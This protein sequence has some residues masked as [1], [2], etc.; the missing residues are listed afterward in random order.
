MSDNIW[1]LTFGKRIDAIIREVQEYHMQGGYGGK[2]NLPEIVKMFKSA[3][4]EIQ[5]VN[6]KLTEAENKILSLEEKIKKME[7]EKNQ[8]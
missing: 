7:T 2:M 6:N 4:T 3:T 8:A 1:L 5:K